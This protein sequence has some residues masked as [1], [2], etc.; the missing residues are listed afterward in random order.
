MKFKGSL[1]SFRINFPD[2]QKRLHESLSNDIAHAAFVWLEAVLAEIPTWSGASR[3]TFLQLAREVEYALTIAPKVQ[4][5]IPYGQR[6]GEGEVTSDPKKGIY[7]FSYST[8]LRRLVHNEYNTPD[9]DPNVF[10]RLLR[11]GPYHFQLKGQEAF[12]KFAGDVRLPYP[13]KSLKVHRHRVQ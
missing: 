11:P 1:V 7:T 5:A 4:S 9:S 12:R 10:Y 13:W 2:Y 8:D 3:A 6:H